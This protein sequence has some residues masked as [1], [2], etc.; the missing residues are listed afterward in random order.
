MHLSRRHSVAEWQWKERQQDYRA[1]L[2]KLRGFNKT[3]TGLSTE[4]SR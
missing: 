3:T 1:C 4:E 2:Q